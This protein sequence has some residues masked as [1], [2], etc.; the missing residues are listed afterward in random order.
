M[1]WST[2]T[3]VPFHKIHKIWLVL[4]LGS[5]VRLSGGMSVSWP[6]IS[7]NGGTA[8]CDTAV[9][10]EPGALCGTPHAEQAVGVTT[11][12]LIQHRLGAQVS[13]FSLSHLFVTAKCRIEIG[14]QG[15]TGMLLRACWMDYGEQSCS[16]IELFKLLQSCSIFA[17]VSLALH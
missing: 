4:L 7:A 10:P 3:E 13:G 14:H 11:E 6:Q 9:F 2:K 5:F 8:C 1:C 15:T 17:T 16:H 12:T